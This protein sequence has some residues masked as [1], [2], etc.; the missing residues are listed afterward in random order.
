LNG[1]LASWKDERNNDTQTVSFKAQ[2]LKVIYDTV[3]AIAGVRAA[4]PKANT[5]LASQSAGQVLIRIADGKAGDFEA[6]GIYNML[7]HRVAT[8]HPTGYMYLWNGRTE[9]GA[10][11]STGVYFVQSGSR[12]LGKFLYRN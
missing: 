6:L 11:A 9:A 2:L 3:P 12:I 10:Q 5:F 4:R 1:L 7:G 8:L